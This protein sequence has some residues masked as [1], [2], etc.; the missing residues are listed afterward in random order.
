MERN[1]CIDTLRVVAILLI[2]YIHVY[3]F[4][5]HTPATTY[6]LALTRIGVPLFFLI[7]G[8]FYRYVVESHHFA[9]HLVKLV[10]FTIALSAVYFLWQLYMG[11]RGYDITS[12]LN[13]LTSFDCWYDFL[14]FNASPFGPHLWY[15]GAA[16]YA[17]IIVFLA[18]RLG[19]LHLLYCL[20]PLLFVL[21]YAFTFTGDVLS[22]R[23]AYLTGLP[24]VGVGCMI[25]EYRATIHQHLSHFHLGRYGILTVI[26]LFCLTVYLEFLAYSQTGLPLRDSYLI[27]CPFAIFLFV[28]SLRHPSAHN[29]RLLSLIGHRYVLYIYGFHLIVITALRMHYKIALSHF[30]LLTTLLVF[31]LSL[32]L[33]Y[34]YVKTKKKLSMLL[35]RK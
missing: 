4:A 18:D 9:S 21:N 31:M 16:I 24:Y 32:L 12:Y 8:Y 22:Y 30:P 25:Y 26:L 11:V 34:L 6:I 35:S 3:S 27:T 17:I 5:V 13:H 10:K 23:N 28:L 19:K 29:T 7:S 15:L 14:I 20:I 33:S 1:Y 2:I